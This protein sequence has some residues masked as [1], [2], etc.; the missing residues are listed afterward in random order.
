VQGDTPSSQ[1]ADD[2]ISTGDRGGNFS[3]TKYVCALWVRYVKL[4]AGINKELLKV[5]EGKESRVESIGKGQN[6]G[7]RSTGVK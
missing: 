1:V 5:K 7:E 3:G 6:R 4:I 2:R